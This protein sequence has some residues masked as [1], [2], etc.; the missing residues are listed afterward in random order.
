MKLLVSAAIYLSFVSGICAQDNCFGNCWENFEKSSLP[1]WEKSN[2][3]LQGLVGCQAPDFSV[4]TIDG[5]PIRLSELKGKVVIINFWFAGCVPCIVENPG[6]NKLVQ[7]Y[8]GRDVVFIAFSR[9][10][11]ELLRETIKAYPFNYQHVSASYDIT[12]PFC[13]FSGWPTNMVLDKNGILR[14]VFAGGPTDM[15]QSD[16]A[17]D[18]IKPVIEKYLN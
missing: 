10:R 15:K 2:A 8:K 13:K 4:K 11:E 1:L 3:I 6:L 17:H 7:E 12:K 18:R 9:D 16:E 14:L 5:K